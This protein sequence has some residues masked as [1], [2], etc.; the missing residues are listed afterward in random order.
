MLMLFFL[1]G[2]IIGQSL[3]MGA[4]IQAFFTVYLALLP[5]SPFRPSPGTNATDGMS[6]EECM[7]DGGCDDQDVCTTDT[8]SNGFCRN[9]P[10]VGCGMPQ[11][12]AVRATAS[13]SG[14]VE[15]DAVA[16][17]ADAQATVTFTAIASACSTFD[18]WEGDL[19][20]SDNP[21]SLVIDRDVDVTAVFGDVGSIGLSGVWEMSRVVNGIGGAVECLHPFRGATDSVSAT[22]TESANSLGFAF[23]LSADADSNGLV[24]ASP[25]Q[26]WFVD[27][28]RCDTIEPYPFSLVLDSQADGTVSGENQTTV[29]ACGC[30][31]VTTATFSGRFVDCNAIRGQLDL[32]LQRTCDDLGDQQCTI[33]YTV[34]AMLIDPSP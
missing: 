33:M 4:L 27:A 17:H 1:I 25:G 3:V 7:T 30:D 29:T 34:G 31:Y 13:G 11:T 12:F 22:V 32:A 16:G 19:S 9:A 14:R 28:V 8:C 21:Q 26:L 18:H 24:D 10:I 2:R 5:N 6:G 15:T 20:G 23:A